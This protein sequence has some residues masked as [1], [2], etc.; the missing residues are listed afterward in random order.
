MSQQAQKS[1]T[2]PTGP[3]HR[4]AEASTRIRHLKAELSAEYERRGLAVVEAVD[5]GHSYRA[6][7]K[8]ANVQYPTIYKA[9]ADWA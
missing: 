8:V 9:Y 7:A 6:I 3:L 2:P 1:Q 5:Q 4:V